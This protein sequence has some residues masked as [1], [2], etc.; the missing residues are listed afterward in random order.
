MSVMSEKTK[1]EAHYGGKERREELAW[2]HAD[3]TRF[4][5]DIVQTE[6]E[7]GTALD[8]GCGTGVDSVYLA[9][10]GWKVT[11]L[12]FIQ[13]ALDMSKELAEQESVGLNLV[14]TDVLEWNNS[15]KFDLL[16][17]SG[18]LHNMPREKI[19][20]YKARI[21]SWLKPGGITIVF[22]VGRVAQQ[23]NK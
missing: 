13:K 5:S 22:S 9:K 15:E 20:S 1:F 4:L 2:H 21:L 3:P 7:P 8:M 10:H 11:S 12:D 23:K 6:S 19:P 14:C 18:L 17:D 16:L